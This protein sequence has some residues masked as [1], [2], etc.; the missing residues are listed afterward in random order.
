MWKRPVAFLVGATDAGGLDG[1]AAVGPADAEFVV[2]A[3]A[4]HAAT[5]A[6]EAATSARRRRVVVVE[7]R[8]TTPDGSISLPA[9][10]RRRAND[11]GARRA[12]PGDLGCLYEP[13][14]RPGVTGGAIVVRSP[15]SMDL[16]LAPVRGA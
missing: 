6:I 5:S 7:E 16:E 1:G 3:G 14:H 15:R 4:W 2:A 12:V 9:P 10:A 13:P 11:A 8:E